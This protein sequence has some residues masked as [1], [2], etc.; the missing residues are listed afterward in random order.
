MGKTYDELDFTDDFLFCHILMKNEELCK[1]LAEL[2]TNR[3]IRRILSIEGQKTIRPTRDGKGVRFDVYFEDDENVVYDIEMQTTR[4]KNLPKR[5]RYYQGMIDLNITS[6]GKDYNELKESYIIFICT[7]DVFGDDRHIYTFENVC[8]ENSNVR[9]GDGVHKI[10]LCANSKK[11][12]CS[13]KLKEFL[14]YFAN[15]IPSG[16]FSRKLDDAVE[17]SKKE[18]KW[19]QSYMTLQ[20]KYREKYQEGQ[21]DGRESTIVLLVSKLLS[22]HKSVEEVADLLDLDIDRVKEIEKK[23]LVTD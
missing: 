7:F 3:K 1:E 17:E 14:D 12:D 11:D 6:K 10:F 21:D 19:R 9:L 5:S 8:I 15:K 22:K 20:E 13:P 16:E 2:I 4:K 18:K 23:M